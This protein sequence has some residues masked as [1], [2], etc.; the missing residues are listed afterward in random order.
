MPTKPRKQNPNNNN[1]VRKNKQHGAEQNRQ[2]ETRPNAV[3]KTTI[4]DQ[5]TKHVIREY[6]LPCLLAKG[7][8]LSLVSRCVRVTKVDIRLDKSSHSDL[9]IHVD[10]YV[11]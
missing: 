10:V 4:V 9:K 2:K 3:Y 5:K 6:D 8:V 7:H 11:K 1:H